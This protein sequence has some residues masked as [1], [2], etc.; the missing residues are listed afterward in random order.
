VIT[1]NPKK[2]AEEET[3]D[4]DSAAGKQTTPFQP[5]PLFD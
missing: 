5:F 4:W 3:D 2:K 1:F